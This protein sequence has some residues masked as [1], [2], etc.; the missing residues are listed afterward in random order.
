MG[1]GRK[2]SGGNADKRV[3]KRKKGVK[4]RKKSSRDQREKEDEYSQVHSVNLHPTLS[5]DP[6]LH[7]VNKETDD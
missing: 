1:R 4:K 3:R 5:H 2:K 6:P 7:N